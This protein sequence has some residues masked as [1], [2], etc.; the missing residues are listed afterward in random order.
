[1]PAD[2]SGPELEGLHAAARG[3]GYYDAVC[4][5]EYLMAGE[6]VYGRRT[7]AVLRV[8]LGV[9]AGLLTVGFESSL[10][11]HYVEGYQSYAD[12]LLHNLQAQL[13]AMR[14]SLTPETLTAELLSDITSGEDYLIKQEARIESLPLQP[15]GILAVWGGLQRP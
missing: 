8:D 14:D 3:L 6:V 9:S 5:F 15:G 7:P 2:L 13:L 4:E 12:E 11:R 10:A 1:V